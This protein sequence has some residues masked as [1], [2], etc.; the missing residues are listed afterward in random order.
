MNTTP[1]QDTARPFLAAMAPALAA[2]PPGGPL[3]VAVSGGSDSLA[4]LL[5]LERWAAAAGRPLRV[6]TIDHGLRHGS[7]AEAET[8]AGLCALRGLPHATLRWQDWDGRGNL[9]ANA[10][11]ARRRLIARW[12]AG[13]GVEAVALGHTLDDQA[14]TFLLR[15]ARGSGVDGLSAMA[16]VSRLGGLLWLR[17]M[18]GLRRDALR[19]WLS[20]LG[21]CWAED[22][23]NADLRFDRVRTR[24]ALATLEGLGIGAEN[25]AATAA[26]MARARLALES[27][28]G[29]LAGACVSVSPGG[30]VSLAPAAFAAAPEEIRLRLL[31]DLLCWVGAESYRPRLTQLAPVAAAVAGGHIGAG[32]TLHGCILRARRGQVVI[33]RE[34]GR[35]AAPV[36]VENGVW[37]KRWKLDIL[38]PRAEGLKIAALGRE[39][40]SRVPDWRQTGAARETLLTTPAIWR[41]DDLVAAPLAGLGNGFSF[42]L[43]GMPAGLAAVSLLH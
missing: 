36:S 2:L 16:P 19:L 38:P 3:G 26:R 1:L 24:A 12:A 10:R 4:L 23:S 42:R 9:Q 15:L 32:L 40:L 28:T 14:E 20:G 27:A 29:S 34:P 6:V 35:V 33:R 21:M 22:P 8:V 25:L 39:G 7:A 13:E 5:L 18:L 43:C 30:E 41:E 31:A 11:S 37:E 17:P